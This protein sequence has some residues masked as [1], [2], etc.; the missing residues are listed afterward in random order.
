MNDKLEMVEICLS[1]KQ[2][3]FVVDT[4]NFYI[5]KAE[6]L[7]EVIKEGLARKEAE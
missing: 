1:R 5:Q 2:W 4:L 3:E 6:E 7:R